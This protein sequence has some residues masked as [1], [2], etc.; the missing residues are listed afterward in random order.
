MY[1]R[2]LCLSNIIFQVIWVMSD[3]LKEN[4]TVHV[5]TKLQRAQTLMER[6]KKALSE[7]TRVSKGRGRER[8]RERKNY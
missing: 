3:I 1:S 8:E 2:I 4:N 5:L 6:K 7:P